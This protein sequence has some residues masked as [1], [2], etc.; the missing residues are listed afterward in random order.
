[1]RIPEKL[2]RSGIEELGPCQ[3]HQVYLYYY[4]R[5]MKAPS[6]IVAMQAREIDCCVDGAAPVAAAGLELEDGG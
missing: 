6:A 3:T 4:K 5:A 2:A 1:M